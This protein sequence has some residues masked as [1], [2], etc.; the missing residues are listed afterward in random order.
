MS[1]AQCHAKRLY[2]ERKTRKS[3]GVT[4]TEMRRTRKSDGGTANAIR[5]GNN[6][7]NQQWRQPTIISTRHTTS[8]HLPRKVITRGGRVRWFV[9]IYL[10]SN[11]VSTIADG[12]I[13]SENVCDFW[14]CHTLGHK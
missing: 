11:H 13:D 5:S 7:I 12:E 10:L 6:S 9:I 8:H 2:R 3:Q 1:A 14:K 4:Q